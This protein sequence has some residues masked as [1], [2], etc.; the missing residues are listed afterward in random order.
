MTRASSFLVIPLAI[1]LSGPAAAATKSKAHKTT[2]ATQAVATSTPTAV[3]TDPVKQVEAF[4]AALLDSMKNAKQLGV[5]GRYNKL[6]P[7]IDASFDFA[8]MTEAIVGPQWG[9]MPEAD[10][11]SVIEAFRRTTIANYARS[12]DG[13]NGEQFVT[14]PQVQDRGGEKVV[15]TQ[16]TRPGNTPIAFIYK[17]DNA[18]GGWKIDDIFANGFVSQVATKRSEYAATLKSGGA[19]LLA[20]KLNAQADASLKGG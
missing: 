3:M 14:N 17:L 11:K 5:Q 12:F 2:P 13:Y 8:A 18:H 6:A 9:S 1:T 15:S 4:H 20:Q 7:A 19:A 10:R 16:M